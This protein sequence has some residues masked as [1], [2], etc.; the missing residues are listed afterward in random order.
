MRSAR[1]VVLLFVALVVLPQAAGA[2]DYP[3]TYLLPVV[4]HTAGTGNPPTYWVSD[5]T[6]YNPND[7]AIVVGLAFFPFG[8][9]NF[10]DGTYPVTLELDPHET[11]LVEDVLGTLFN[12]E[13]D[14]K[15]FLLFTSANDEIPSNPED[16]GFALTS[17][18][19][20]TGSPQGTY[21]QTVSGTELYWNGS[22]TPS[23]ITGIRNG[24]HY[25]SNLGV[26]NLSLQ[27]IRLHWRI[28]TADGS[29]LVWGTFHLRP[30]EGEQWSLTSLL[31]S[32]SVDPV[33]DPGSVE[34][35]LDPE[36]VTPDPCTAD[37]VNYFVAY[38]SKVDGNPDGTGDAEFIWAIPA[39]IPP[40]GMHCSN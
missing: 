27:E 32:A 4:A 17:R 30:L 10:F 11:R 26:V 40:A 13:T 3:N 15:G 9:S 2:Q 33:L 25:R 7:S 14:L 38:V 20:N 5:V 12:V 18:T 39:E 19:Y 37:M 21:G 22:A 28:R 36:D 16:S 31:T 23:L 24:E 35:W 29:P 6:L 34:L 8:Q 1:F